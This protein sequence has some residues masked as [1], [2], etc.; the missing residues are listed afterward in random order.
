MSTPPE[1]G[2]RG[3]TLIEMI[4][5]IVIVSVGLVGI[6]S[7]LNIAVFQ[8][9]DPM[10]RKQ[11]LSIAE[12]LLEEVEAMPFTYCDPDDPLAATAASGGCTAGYSEASGPETIAS[13]TEARPTVAAPSP[14]KTFDNVNDYH[15]LTLSPVS[16]ADGQTTFPGYSATVMVANDGNFGAT[17]SLLPSD[18]VLRVTV[19]VCH[20]STQPCPLGADSLTLHGYRTRHSPNALP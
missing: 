17:G 8:S 12:S 18:A 7:V 2:Q 6:M 11:M 15:D 4:V 10:I 14:P 5:F 3:L 9:A 1:A 19:T 13:D 20:S 16:S